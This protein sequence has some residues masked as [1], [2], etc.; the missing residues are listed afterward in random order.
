[1]QSVIL[2]MSGVLTDSMPSIY[3][4]CVSKVSTVKVCGY[5]KFC[6]DSDIKYPIRIRAI[7]KFDIHADGLPTKTACNPQ[8]KLKV[9]KITLL[10]FNVQIKN[11]LKHDRN[12]V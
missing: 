12:R 10:A 11:V 4:L 1:M 8:F 2:Q 7:Q 6:S 5:P 3:I 9:T